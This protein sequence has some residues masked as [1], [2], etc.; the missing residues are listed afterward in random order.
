MDY[1]YTSYRYLGLSHIYTFKVKK[2]IPISIAFPKAIIGSEMEC[3][4]K[5]NRNT[6]HDQ[7]L[8][9]KRS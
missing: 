5:R 1:L 6:T 7:F 4:P 2:I 3:T 8:H 9:P